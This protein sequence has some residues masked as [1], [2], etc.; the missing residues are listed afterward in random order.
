M[1]SP[2]SV[3]CGALRLSRVRM[4]YSSFL[5]F[6]L[7]FSGTLLLATTNPLGRFLVTGFTLLM[8]FLFFYL[9]SLDW[10][11]SRGDTVKLLQSMSAGV[12]R[13]AFY[14]VG[15]AAAPFLVGSGLG[16]IAGFGLLAVSGMLFVGSVDV[17]LSLAFAYGFAP[18]V[19]GCLG[20]LVTGVVAEWRR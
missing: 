9:F 12:G 4:F 3:V 19:A 10:L 1:A 8:G 16:A 20:G 18:V 14:L 17:D 2:F 11:R 7:S 5:L 13:I 15:W 6:A